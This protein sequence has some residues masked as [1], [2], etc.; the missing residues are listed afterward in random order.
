[1]TIKTIFFSFLFLCVCGA[2]IHADSPWVQQPTYAKKVSHKLEYGLKNILFGWTVPF[3][4]PFKEKFRSDTNR[5]SWYAFGVGLSRGLFYTANGL[6]Q[7]ATFPLPIDFI[8]MGDGVQHPA[9][10]NKQPY[11]QELVERRALRDQAGYGDNEKISSF[12]TQP[13]HYPD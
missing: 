5:R 7:T 8:D 2:P 11:G 10:T 13:H 4:E 3:T 1:M 6:I 12:P 9:I